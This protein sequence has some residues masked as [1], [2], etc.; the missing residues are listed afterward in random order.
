[1]SVGN[2]STELDEANRQLRILKSGGGGGGGGSGA[3]SGG[4]AGG[5]GGSGRARAPPPPNNI[6]ANTATDNMNP[7]RPPQPPTGQLRRESSGPVV[8]NPFSS[9]QSAPSSSSSAGTGLLMR[10]F[11]SSTPASGA[12]SGPVKA[13]T[14]PPVKNPFA[15]AGSPLQPQQPRAQPGQGPSFQQQQQQQHMQH[16]QFL[17]QQRQQMQMQQRR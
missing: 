6:F 7:N 13:G 17:Q 10:G 4:G 15:A 8:Q 14:T 2:L 11:G 3:N 12:A 9:S 5:G 16:Q 1:M